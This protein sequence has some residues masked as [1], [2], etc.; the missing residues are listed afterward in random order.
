[1]FLKDRPQPIACSLLPL[2]RKELVCSHCPVKLPL[3][4]QG[5][6]LL[7]TMTLQCLE[8]WK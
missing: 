2:F 5:E 3:L 1:V 6:L 8:C 4:L 7:P